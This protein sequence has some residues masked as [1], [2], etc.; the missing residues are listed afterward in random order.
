MVRLGI[1]IGRMKMMK[2]MKTTIFAGMLAF[3]AMPPALGEDE[4]LGRV[5]ASS[6][7]VWPPGSWLVPPGIFPA[8]YIN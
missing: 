1:W 5:D 2:M 6:T 8:N 7:I 3:M 4:L